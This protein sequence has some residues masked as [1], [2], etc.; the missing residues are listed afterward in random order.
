MEDEGEALGGRESI[1]N[2][3]EGETDGVGQERI[4]FRTGAGVVMGRDRGELFVKL[5]FAS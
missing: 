5:V 2:D 1:E 4:L 3:H